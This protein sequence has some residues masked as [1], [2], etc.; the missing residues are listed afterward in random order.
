MTVAGTGF[1]VR[2][3]IDDAL[4]WLCRIHTFHSVE[5]SLFT[6][7]VSWLESLLLIRSAVLE[8]RNEKMLHTRV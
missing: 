5:L 2:C 6:V 4:L 8:T 1:R 3:D 7:E